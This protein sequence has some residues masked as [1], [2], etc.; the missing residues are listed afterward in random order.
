ARG[1]PGGELGVDGPAKARAAAGIRVARG[2]LR[3][4]ILAGVLHVGPR[5]TFIGAAPTIELHLLD[6]EG[7]LYGRHVRVDLCERLRSVERFENTDALVAAMHEDVRNARRVLAAGA[8]ACGTG[9][10]PLA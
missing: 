5:P 4:G 3:E 7:N 10:I 9:R 1:V 6:W 8:G 2:V